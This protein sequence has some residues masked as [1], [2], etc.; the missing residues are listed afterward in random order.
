MITQHTEMSHSGI[1]LNAIR[2]LFGSMC[3][4]AVNGI[5]YKSEVT[6]L[7][8]AIHIAKGSFYDKDLC[9]FLTGG[10]HYYFSWWFVG[11]HLTQLK[12]G[13]GAISVLVKLS[14]TVI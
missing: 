10:H 11:S 3:R 12:H 9:F 7:D 6:S 2:I 5:P 1:A 13:F 8:S 4:R 14:Q